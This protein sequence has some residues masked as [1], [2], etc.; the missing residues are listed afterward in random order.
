MYW[1]TL[2]VSCDYIYDN[3]LPLMAHF[4]DK[5]YAYNFFRFL[6]TMLDLFDCNYKIKLYKNTECID[7]W[8]N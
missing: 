5:R 8:K 4:G 3:R 6:I 1:I 7:K 2:E